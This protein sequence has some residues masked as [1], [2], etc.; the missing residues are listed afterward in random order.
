MIHTHGER[1]IAH[2]MT[3]D[4]GVENFVLQVF[5]VPLVMQEIMPG[6]YDELSIT[7]FYAREKIALVKRRTEE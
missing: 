4:A 1:F 5:G 2:I 7:A 6:K 3:K